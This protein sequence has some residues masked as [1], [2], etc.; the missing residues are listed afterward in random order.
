[1]SAKG[2][3]KASKIVSSLSRS[4]SLCTR[5]KEFCFS[6]NS[7]YDFSVKISLLALI[8]AAMIFLSLAG[9]RL[10]DIVF[11]PEPFNAS[12]GVYKFL[13]AG[14]ERVAG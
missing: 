5:L 7:L 6:K 3:D 4:L 1:M 10:F 12:G 11:L 13:L 9:L 8:K 14:E 2:D